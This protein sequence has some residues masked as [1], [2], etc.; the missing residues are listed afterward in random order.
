MCSRDT[1]TSL[2]E[3]EVD[4]SDDYRSSFNG[5]PVRQ[6][7]LVV[8]I[9]VIYGSGHIKTVWKEPNLRVRAYKSLSVQTAKENAG[10]FHVG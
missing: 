7:L 5:I 10:L 9:H 8:D 2:K 6:R 1:A 4:P 3:A